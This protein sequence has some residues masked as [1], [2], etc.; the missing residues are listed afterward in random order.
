MKKLALV[1]VV[2]A[3]S[4]FAVNAE[5][6]GIDVGVDIGVNGLTADEIGLSASPWIGYGTALG[7]LDVYFTLGY[8]ATVTPDFNSDDVY[9]DIGLSKSFGDL[10]AA[11]AITNTLYLGDAGG[12]GL[13]LEPSVSY[14]IGDLTLGAALPMAMPFDYYKDFTLGLGVSADYAVGD[15]GL[16][17]YADFSVS[18]DFSFDDVGVTVS[19]PLAGISFG[20]D[21]CFSGFDTELGVDL[22]IS[23]S[24]SF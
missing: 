23:A 14:A 1:F 21:A 15:L 7:G 20:L 6:L 24:Y 19:Y 17:A 10:T 2:A 8:D 9:L 11:L 13:D 18:P 22:T 12:Y 16:G 4:V 5:P 3:A